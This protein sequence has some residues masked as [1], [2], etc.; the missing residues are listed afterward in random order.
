MS[1]RSRNSYHTRI[2]LVRP[3]FRKY[4]FRVYI[5]L[6]QISIFQW[7]YHVVLGWLEPVEHL[8]YVHNLILISC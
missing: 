7:R 6:L 3:D 2:Y 8:K 1:I 4:R 5:K